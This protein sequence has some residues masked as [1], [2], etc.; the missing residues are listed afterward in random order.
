[1]RWWGHQFLFVGHFHFW[2]AVQPQR[3]EGRDGSRRHSTCAWKQ[4]QAPL[5]NGAATFFE[6]QSDS[7][8]GQRA[9]E[10]N[11]IFPKN[12][13]V[14]VVECRGHLCKKFSS[15]QIPERDVVLFSGM[16]WSE[17]QIWS[18]RL[19][20]LNTLFLKGFLNKSRRDRTHARNNF[21]VFQ[22][23]SACNNPP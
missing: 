17:R 19:S 6:L 22:T 4:P 1:M 2:P 11:A 12:S 20:T 9:T 16:V 10:A 23:K 8:W 14:P 21:S 3:I 13:T 7:V 5:K 18:G 15:F